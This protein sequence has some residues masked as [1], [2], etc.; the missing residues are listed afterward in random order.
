MAIPQEVGGAYPKWSRKL[1]QGRSA[2]GA[3]V[4]VAKTEQV[5]GA[6]RGCSLLPLSYLTQHSHIV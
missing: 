6:W 4:G 1:Q 3:V 5:S 2:A